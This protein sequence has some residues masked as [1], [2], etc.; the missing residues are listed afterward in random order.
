ME[1]VEVGGFRIIL[2][3]L[4]FFKLLVNREGFSRIVLRP[5]TGG[6]VDLARND[7]VDFGSELAVVQAAVVGEVPVR[8]AAGRLVS[9][10]ARF[11]SRTDAMSISDLSKRQWS[12]HVMT[13]HQ[14]T[15]CNC[16]Q[17]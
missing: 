12:G 11:E 5:D 1:E 6:E 13:R 4:D 17:K 10:E 8:G 3:L 16:G 15:S 14:D 7:D 9:N 2:L